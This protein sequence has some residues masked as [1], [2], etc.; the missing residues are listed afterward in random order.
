MQSVKFFVPV[1][2]IWVMFHE[3]AHVQQGYESRV[4]IGSELALPYRIL[5]PLNFDPTQTYP[6]LLFLHGAGERGSDNQ[7]QLAHFHHLFLDAVNSESHPAIVVFPQC[8][9]DDY[10]ANANIDRYPDRLD[11]EFQNGGE[12][13][14]AL[15]SVLE[16]MDS[17]SC[18]PF[19]DK[20][21]VYVG[22]LSMGGMGTFEI[23]YRRPDMF[24]AAFPIC[25]GAHPATVHT[26]AKEVPLWVF[27]GDQDHIV[28]PDFSVQMV[29]AIKKAGGDPKLTL[30]EGAKHDS[31]KNASVEPELLPWIFSQRK[32]ASL[33]LHS[34]LTDHAI[35][36]RGRPIPVIGKG[37]PDTPVTITWKDQR[38]ETKT[39][40]NGNFIYHLPAEPAGGPYQIAIENNEVRILLSNIYIG[41][42]WFA[43]GQS[44]MEWTLQ[45]S[46][47][48]TDEIATAHFD[49]IRFFKSPREM[50]FY[51]KNDW[52]TST[53]W[54]I[55]KGKGLVDYS[56][57]AYYFAKK[58][59]LES[60]IPIGIVD[61]SWGGTGIETWMSDM[62]LKP[63]EI[64]DF[65]LDQLKE[66]NKPLKELERE[67]DSIFQV[68]KDVEYKKGIGMDEKWYERQS[69]LSGWK[70]I[71][72]PGYWEDQLP[73]YRNFDGAMWYRKSFDV[74]IEFLPH[75][76]R[77][78]LSQIDDHNICWIN[79]LYIGETYFS[80]SW[81]NY[82]IPKGLL[83]EKDN[84]IVLRVFDVEGKGGLT[85]LDTY[86]DFYPEGNNKVRSRL[87]GTWMVRP[88]VVFER[89][90]GM[91]LSTARIHPNH[92]P[93]L[94]FNGMVYPYK[95]FGIKGVIWYQGE[96]NKTNA[97][98]YRKLFPALILDWRRLWKSPEMP[99]YY[100]QIANYGEVS[101]QPEESAAAELRE[102]QYLARSLPH[103]GM[104]VTI[105]IGNASDIHPLNKKDVGERLARHALK[106]QYGKSNMIT[107]GP[108]YI[109]HKRKG[110]KLVVTFENAEGLTTTDGRSPKGFA[111]AS[112]EGQFFFAFAR[113]KKGKIELWHP[114]VT[115]PSHV[116]YSWGESPI[117]NLINGEKLPALPF[118]TD[119]RRGITEGQF[120]NYK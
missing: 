85:G 110:K 94:L 61:A 55:A 5:I 15:Q 115:H 37:Y 70:P 12:P 103:T 35:F 74:P 58:I 19:V 73:E 33:K 60:N 50:E 30:Y 54:E 95:E 13:T 25:G 72:V 79:G 45:K 106:N 93:G 84:E 116:R 97:F 9:T 51:P 23:L 81:T 69:D 117:V 89:G 6:L 16:L 2:F 20:S 78:W 105:D 34:Y 40:E 107:D 8:P 24:A 111:I 17:L 53:G 86:F 91:Y 66:R 57:V 76:I 42:V 39:K 11:I 77:I 113:I 104:A 83:R 71:E 47:G 43:S 52:E 112:E 28:L 26:Y 100:V 27:H 4:F 32:P 56:G 90:D 82:L 88:G 7:S 108:V 36:Q 1:L 96:S 41:D 49:Q 18:L 46:Q 75:D 62:A 64:Y 44:N 22:G 65:Q 14:Q 87:N 109:S 59:H 102:S 63:F 68:W 29:E 48:G 99:F 114:E 38:H 80:K 10:W 101:N 67:S 120:K 119:R 21:R 118:R 3:I 98:A 31:W 92:Y